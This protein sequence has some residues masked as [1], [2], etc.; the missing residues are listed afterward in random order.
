[1]KQLECQPSYWF[2]IIRDFV[3]HA[4]R[5]RDARK[6]SIHLMIFGITYILFYFIYVFGQRGW[7]V[8][9][10]FSVSCTQYNVFLRFHILRPHSYGL[11]IYACL[12]FAFFILVLTINYRSKREREICAIDEKSFEM[13][14]FLS[15][16]HRRRYCND[17]EIDHKLNKELNLLE[18][19]RK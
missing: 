8:F 14:L 17:W 9:F 10:Y 4:Q 1:M 7:I 19:K 13:A 12:S 3:F 16:Q 2:I 11:T 5:K 15:L 6:I 18:Y